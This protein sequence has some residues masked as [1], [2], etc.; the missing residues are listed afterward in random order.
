MTYLISKITI[1]PTTTYCNVLMLL[2]H[3]KVERKNKKDWRRWNI[4]TQERK[5]CDVEIEIISFVV[6]GSVK[7]TIPQS[8]VV[9]LGKKQKLCS[10]WCLA[11]YIWPR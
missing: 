5:V 11:G 6:D 3:L 4:T 8:T 1:M 10:L 7:L 2:P 9:N